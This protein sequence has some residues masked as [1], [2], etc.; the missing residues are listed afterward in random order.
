M[1]FKLL[2]CVLIVLYDP[3]E[4]KSFVLKLNFSLNL[5]PGVFI[6]SHKCLNK[7][8][9]KLCLLLVLLIIRSFNFKEAKFVEQLSKP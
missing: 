3:L 9:V 7:I 1:L 5:Q 2:F 6:C 4:V 8:F